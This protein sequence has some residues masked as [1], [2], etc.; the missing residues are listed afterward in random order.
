MKTI[1]GCLA[2]CLLLFSCV[3]LSAEAPDLPAQYSHSLPLTISGKQGVVSLRLPQAVYLHSRSA[4]LADLRVFDATGAIQPFALYTPSPVTHSQQ[5][6]WLVKQFP[7]LAD[8]NKPVKSIA[9]D[10][11]TSADGSVLS[12]K[13]QA[14]QAAPPAKSLT[15]LVLDVGPSTAL[16]GALRFKPP[17]TPYSAQIWLE[18]S[19][20]LKR[21]ETIGAAELSWLVNGQ[22]TLANDRLEFT[23][24][25]FRYARLSWR[26]GEPVN[27]ASIEAESVEKTADAPVLERLVLSPETGHEPDDLLYRASIAIPVERLALSFNEPNVVMPAAIG[28][29]YERPA[30]KLGQPSEWVFEALSRHVFYQIT[31]DGEVRRSGEW[32]VPLSHYADWVIRPQTSSNS[33]PQLTLFWQ[34]ATLV[35]LTAGQAPYRVA[36]GNDKAK[37]AAVEMAQVAPGFSPDELTRLELAQIGPLETRPATESATSTAVKAS[38]AAQARTVILWAVLLAG[39]VVLGMMVWRL[40]RQMKADG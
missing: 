14:G 12:V 7:I 23:P 13:T 21:W 16:I 31:Q 36:F 20:N 3:G 29:Y 11:K 34:P 19:D 39:L 6:T 15:G 38:Q 25:H 35:F 24:R 32:A 22:E 10:I 26:G 28:R 4:S 30:R 18:V 27:F 40:V 9:L 17:T 33:R 1:I 2:A 8:R 5:Q 37:S